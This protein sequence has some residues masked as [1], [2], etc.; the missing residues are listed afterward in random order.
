MLPGRFCKVLT[1]SRIDKTSSIE[2]PV[3]YTDSHSYCVRFASWNMCSYNCMRHEYP[4]RVRFIV[5]I[6]HQKYVYA[7]TP[8]PFAESIQCNNSY[9]AH[10]AWFN[11]CCDY[12]PGQPPGNVTQHSPGVGNCVDCLVGAGDRNTQYERGLVHSLQARSAVWQDGVRNF[13]GNTQ[14]LILNT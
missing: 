10:N 5:R 6:L 9:I 4:E 7:T 12:P 1:K 3:L 8:H 14:G 11:S 13:A 2:F